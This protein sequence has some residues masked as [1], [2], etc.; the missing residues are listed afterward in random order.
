V[1][2]PNAVGTNVIPQFDYQLPS[3]RLLPIEY[4]DY[5]S[6][7]S[8]NAQNVF[9]FELRNKLQTK[10]EG[11]VVNL[12]NWHL[13]TDWNLRPLPG[14]PTFSDLYSDLLI[15]PRSWLSLESLLAFNLANGQCDLSLNTLTFQLTSALSWSL[16]QYYLA[17]DLSTGTTSLG[18]GN[19]LF[20]STLFYRLDENWAL[21]AYQRFD[22]AS[23]Q[24]QEQGY[25]IYRDLRSWTAAV[26]F[27]VRQNPGGPTDVGFGFTFSL[28]A[29]PRYGLGYDA[30][31]TVPLLGY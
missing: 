18:L 10:R 14:Q 24:L 15:R 3:L 2:T 8:I 30:I 11:Q 1:P 27:R 7:D 31:R 20:S 22:A 12:L 16:T 26:T 17:N 6:I 29:Y 5:N 9:R 23:G 4:P 13:Y 21:R 28:K 25:S 19:N